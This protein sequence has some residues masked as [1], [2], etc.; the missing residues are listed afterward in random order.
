MSDDG[1]GVTDWKVMIRHVR[2]QEDTAGARQT[3]RGGTRTRMNAG[4]FVSMGY[5]VWNMHHGRLLIGM[6]GVY[7]EVAKGPTS[8][9]GVSRL[10]GMESK[11]RG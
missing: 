4:L 3:I 10:M 2:R 5:Q 8:V 9:T 7:D 6:R 1:A 11:S